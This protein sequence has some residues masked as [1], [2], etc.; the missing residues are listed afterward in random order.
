MLEQEETERHKLDRKIAAEEDWVRYGVTAR[1]KRK[2]RTAGAICMRLAG[3]AARGAAN[4]GGR[5]RWRRRRRQSGQQVIDAEGIGKSFDGR[6]VVRD[7]STRVMRGD[8]IGIVGANGAGKT[9]LLKLLTGELP[10]DQGKVKLGTNLAQVT[11]DQRRAALDPDAKAVGRA[12]GRGG[13]TVLVGGQP[14]HVIGYMKDFLFTPEQARTP[15]GVLS[16][17]ER[18]GCCWHALCPAVEP[19]GAGRA[20]Q[21]SGPGDAR[22]ACRSCWRTIPARCCWSATTAISWTGW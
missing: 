18:A 8:R 16:G 12:D 21:R 10:P 14:R 9:T 20:D 13:D 2:S 22:S 4:P 17:G 1:R 3:A 11:L 19:A 7:L 15:V 6:T 5:C